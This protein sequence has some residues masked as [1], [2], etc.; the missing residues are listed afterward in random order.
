MSIPAGET[1]EQCSVGL[2][3][4]ALTSTIIGSAI[5]VHS[6]LGPGLLESVTRS[7][8]AKNFACATSHS[9]LKWSLPSF[10][11]D[12]KQPRSIASA[13]L[14]PTKLWSN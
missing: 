9:E 3:S 11:K 14:L 13:S 1:Q 8:C 7:V 4:E 5:E 10:T 2:L 6:Q 12:G